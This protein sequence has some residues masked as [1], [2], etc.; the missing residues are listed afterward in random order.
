ARDGADA[1][2]LTDGEHRSAHAVTAHHDRRVPR[3]LVEPARPEARLELGVVRDDIVAGEI[4]Q[5]LQKTSSAE[6]SL[7][8]VQRPTEL[9]HE[10][11]HERGLC[12]AEHSPRAVRL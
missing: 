9:S 3:V 1:D 6:V 5:A 7:V 12:R 2:A 11:R 10:A 8:R 4:A